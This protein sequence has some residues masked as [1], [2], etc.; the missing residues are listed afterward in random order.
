MVRHNSERQRNISHK[1]IHWTVHSQQF[2]FFKISFNSPDQSWQYFVFLHIEFD[3]PSQSLVQLITDAKSIGA[4]IIIIIQSWVKSKHPDDTFSIPGFKTLREDRVKLKGG[5]VCVFIREELRP[6]QVDLHSKMENIKVLWFVVT[7]TT[8]R[9]MTIC[10][11]FH[12]PKP[13]YD[14]SHF[15]TLLADNISCPLDNNAKSIFVLTGDINKLNTTKLQLQQG[16][17][18]IVKV[19]THDKTILDQFIINRPYLLV[20]RSLNP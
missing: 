14:L 1:L 3:Q 11:T 16:L 12:P 5:C 7:L 9:M 18:Q 15:K 4:D 8:E 17:K 10:M 20:C 13:I 2:L 6:R 19:P